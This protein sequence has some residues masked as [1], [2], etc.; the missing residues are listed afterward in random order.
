MVLETILSETILSGYAFGIDWLFWSWA[1]ITAI[2]FIDIIIP[3]PLPFVD[4]AVLI[5]ISVILLLALALRGTLNFLS[6]IWGYVTHPITIAFTL[7]LLLLIIG[8]KI[9]KKN[10]K[11]KKK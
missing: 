1:I 11:V 3:D 5:T 9:Y 6:D 8:N 10:V 2:A 7:T 4:E